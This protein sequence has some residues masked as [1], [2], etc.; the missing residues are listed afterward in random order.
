MKQK[1]S[2]YYSI[3]KQVAGNLM[4]AGIEAWDEGY[5]SVTSYCLEEENKDN[6]KEDTD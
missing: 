6:G 2:P 4:V 3:I 1:D 5:Y